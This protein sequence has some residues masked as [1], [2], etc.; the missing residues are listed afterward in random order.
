MY[1]AVD[2]RGE[3]PPAVGVNYRIPLPGAAILDGLLHASV[4]FPGLTIE[5]STDG[6][7]TWVAYAEPVALAAP[8]ALRTRSPD[9]RSS[10][11]TRID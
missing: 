11:I 6:G 7:Q 1:R 2:L 8:V 9:G 5:Y 10:R 3:L 4:Q